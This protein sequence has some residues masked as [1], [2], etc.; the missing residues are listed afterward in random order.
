MANCQHCAG[1]GR[2]ATLVKKRVPQDFALH[3]AKTQNL[4]L[5]DSYDYCP[6]CGSYQGATAADTEALQHRV[7]ELEKLLA[8]KV[9]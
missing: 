6:H 4:Q 8:E 9:K 2:S 1:E 5:Q 3:L 7:T